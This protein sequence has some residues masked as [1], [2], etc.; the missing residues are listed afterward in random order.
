MRHLVITGILALAML[1]PAD[2]ACGQ[3]DY[4]YPGRGAEWERRSAE[5]MKMDQAKLDEAVRYAL[6]NE[7]SGSRDLRQA[8]LK[9]F[10]HEPYHEILGPT[11]KRGGPA[12]MILKKGYLVASWG[13]VHRV[14]MTFSVTKSY[15]A[16]TAGLAWDRGLIRSIGD[17]VRDYVWDGSFQGKH[18]E[19]I[20][21]VHLL[22]QSS[23]WYGQLWGGYDW[24]DRPPAEGDVN[25]WR[26]RELREPGTFFEYNDV[27]VNLLAYS[28][29]QVW[30][31]PLPRVLKEEVMDPIGASSTWRWYG[32]ENSWTV[33]DGLKVQSVSGGGHSGGGIFIS[34]EDHARFGLLHL[35]GGT[36]NGTRILS[37][38]WMERALTPSPA[39]ENYGFM[40]WLDPNNGNERMKALS[41]EGFYA[42]GFGG[43][44]IIVEPEL[45]LVIVTRWLEPAKAGDFLQMVLGAME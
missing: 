14:D 19:L 34:T 35:G 3:D 31:L 1:V 17:P 27:R 26:A 22:N 21:W 9:G 44:Y 8:I 20:S 18:N 33:V 13:D 2:L 42:A 40:W 43:N 16:T 23:D 12:G 24:A 7:Y 4:Y 29:L 5:D 25:D 41:P 11:K 30:R 37:E 32:Y 28:L 10:Q 45:D 36:W 38:N 15:L 6:D 39:N